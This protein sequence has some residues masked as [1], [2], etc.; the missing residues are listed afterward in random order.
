MET[1]GCSRNIN[2]LME[3]ILAE[4]ARKRKNIA[5]NE[6]LANK[7]HFKRGDLLNFEKEALMREKVEKKIKDE[8]SSEQASLT[9]TSNSKL[10]LKKER[11]NEKELI[12]PREEVVRLLRAKNLPIR[13]FGETDADS[14]HRLR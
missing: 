2:L 1:S 14:C 5:D 11:K 7:K 8:L 13:L 10:F 3:D 12:L 9:H 6:I 4:I